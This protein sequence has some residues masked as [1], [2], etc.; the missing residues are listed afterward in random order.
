ME[1]PALTTGL[2]AVNSFASIR[3]P[4]DRV[5]GAAVGWPPVGLAALAWSCV[6]AGGAEGLFLEADGQ[7][8]GLRWRIL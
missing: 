6:R 7:S 4:G 2:S 8:P 5:N 1:G 3:R